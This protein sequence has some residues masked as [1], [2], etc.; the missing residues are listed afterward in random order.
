VKVFS[1]F[2]NSLPFPTFPFLPANLRCTR[3]Y[4]IV[5]QLKKGL[6]DAIVGVAALT[7]SYKKISTVKKSG[8]K[9]AKFFHF[10]FFCC[11]P[12][13]WL[14]SQRLWLTHIH[15]YTHNYSWWQTLSPSLKAKKKNRNNNE[16][17]DKLLALFL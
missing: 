17:L 7:K 10:A 13:N 11:V 3:Q 5:E 2:F 12:R 14:C 1:L 6:T 9:P 15:T 4:A 8:Q 16:T